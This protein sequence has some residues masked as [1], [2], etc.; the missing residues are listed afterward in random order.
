AWYYVSRDRLWWKHHGKIQ[1]DNSAVK[2]TRHRPNRLAPDVARVD[3]PSV[4]AVFS[5]FGVDEIKNA[6]VPRRAACGQRSP[7]RIGTG[8]RSREKLAPDSRGNELF[9]EWHN[10]LFHKRIEDFKCRA[11]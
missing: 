11:I 1:G 9:Q 3:Q 10:T 5:L 6:V 7:A 2:P 8:S 4:D